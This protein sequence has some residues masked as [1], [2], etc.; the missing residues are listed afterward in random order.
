ME[1]EELKTT[2]GFDRL[3]KDNEKEIIGRFL[4]GT[5]FRVVAKGSE[6]KLRGIKWRNTRPD[7]IIGDDLENDEIVMNDERRT[8]FKKWFNNALLPCGSKH[9]IV[10]IVGT[11][12][13]LD[14][15]LEELMP[16]LNH[17]CTI[18]TPLREHWDDEAYQQ[19]CKDKDIN[20]EPRVWV[21]Y[22]YRAHDEDFSH[23]LW[24]EQ[25]D[26][27]RLHRVRQGYLEMGF[28]EGYSQEY[29]NYPIDETTAYFRKKDFIKWDKELN[30]KDPLTYYIGADLA[31]SEKDARAFSV[32]VVV[33]VDHRGRW[34]TKDVSR[35]RGDSLEIIDEMFRLT[36]I[37]KQ[38]IMFV[39][40]ENIART[41]GP[42]LDKTMRDRKTF[43]TVEPMTASQD[44][45]KRA[46]PLQALMRQGMV[47]FDYEAEWF[48]ALQNEMLQFPRGKYKDQVDAFAWI[49][50]GVES[51]V[52]APTQAEA[53]EEDYL[54][55]YEST[56]DD[57]SHMGGCS[58]TGY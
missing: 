48:P 21:S 53:E 27:A 3:E 44:K 1:N 17:P 29:L 39:E 31:I 37:Y 42:V 47:E 26:R 57:F 36:A 7:L 40:N 51:I 25:Y 30:S 45:V 33:G 58:I 52:N 8:K 6:Q 5:R 35:F 20:Y 19:Y 28:P 23:I 49:A 16:V 34:K 32:F 54:D 38:D 46:R 55:E 41:L 18:N 12:L 11:I 15:L 22:R 50:I 10:R 2:F 9:A 24:P 56:Y 14:S 43:F 4:D 13:H